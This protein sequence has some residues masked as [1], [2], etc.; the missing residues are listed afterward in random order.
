MSLKTQFTSKNTKYK[1]SKKQLRN[2][3][4]YEKINAL[5]DSEN[6]HKLR[7]RGGEC[8]HNQVIVTK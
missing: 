7:N 4:P 3:F 6:Q 2:L 8:N 1:K 5:L